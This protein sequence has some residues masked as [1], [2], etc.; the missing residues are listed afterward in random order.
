MCWK[1][2]THVAEVVDAHDDDVA[3]CSTRG[4]DGAVQPPAKLVGEELR[5][6]VWQRHKRRDGLYMKKIIP[7]RFSETEDFVVLCQTSHAF[8]HTYYGL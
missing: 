5:G 2:D 4:N 8:S 7:L 1:H 3:F 6:S